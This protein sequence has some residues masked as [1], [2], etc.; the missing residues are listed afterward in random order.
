M[1]HEDTYPEEVEEFYLSSEDEDE[2]V[3]YDA[4]MA[5]VQQAYDRML[6]AEAKAANLEIGYCGFPCDGKCS[7]CCGSGFDMEEEV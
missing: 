1:S 2:T 7:S 3:Y 6:E 4:D 5:A